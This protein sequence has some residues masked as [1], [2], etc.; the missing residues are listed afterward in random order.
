MESGSIYQRTVQHGSIPRAAKAAMADNPDTEAF[1]TL[2]FS[3]AGR[4]IVNTHAPERFLELIL[5]HI[6]GTVAKVTN[7]PSNGLL[8]IAPIVQTL[9]QSRSN[10]GEGQSKNERNR[11]VEST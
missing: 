8:S 3:T 1:R 6:L 2:A 4:F 10:P 9:V 11:L 5:E 7:D